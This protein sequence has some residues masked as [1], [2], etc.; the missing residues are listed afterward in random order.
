MDE[1]IE[2][3]FVAKTGLEIV[4]QENVSYVSSPT[5]QTWSNISMPADPN[6][7]TPAGHT[8][9]DGAYRAMCREDS[10]MRVLLRHHGGH[11]SALMWGW[12]R[13][14]EEGFVPRCAAGDFAPRRLAS[15]LL[16]ALSPTCTGRQASR[17]IW[18][19][20]PHCWQQCK[21]GLSSCACRPR[22]HERRVEFVPSFLRG[23][24]LSQH[25]IFLRRLC[26]PKS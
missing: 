26:V 8:C 24:Q 13:A 21:I 18:K 7:R 11:R 16:G 15:C 2:K 6:F 17:Y 9:E 25:F 3:V 20:Q 4:L 14:C 1:I 10:A 23:M 12:P 22:A 19:L 5:S